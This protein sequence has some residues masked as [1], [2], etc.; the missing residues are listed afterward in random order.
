MASPDAEI[1][2]GVPD[3]AVVI[4]H[5]G[6]AVGLIVALGIQLIPLPDRLI[7]ITG[8]ADAARK[9]WIVLSLI[10]GM[11]WRSRGSAARCSSRL[12]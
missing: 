7:E 6:L 5:I 12:R 4:R 3:D 8:D 11:I 9:A 1:D 10:L 2:E